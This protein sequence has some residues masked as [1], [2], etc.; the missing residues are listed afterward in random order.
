MPSM[1]PNMQP[2]VLFPG[3]C[4]WWMHAQAT[5]GQGAGMDTGPTDGHGMTPNVERVQTPTSLPF[6]H[7]LTC[8]IRSSIPGE[9]YHCLHPTRCQGGAALGVQEQEDPLAAKGQEGA[10]L[11]KVGADSVHPTG[12]CHS[13]FWLGDH[14]R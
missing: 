9:P 14:C 3:E 8:L 4:E 13:I 1:F 12:N 2:P 7:P 10:G 5:M 6:I 11:G